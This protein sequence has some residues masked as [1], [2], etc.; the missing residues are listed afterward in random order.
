M[1]VLPVRLTRIAPAGTCTSPRLPTRVNRLFSTMNAESSMGALPSPVIS[2][3]PSN[4]VTRLAPA[5]PVTCD[6]HAAANNRHATTS[7]QEDILFT[8]HIEVSYPMIHLLGIFRE[9]RIVNPGFKDK[10]H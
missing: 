8:R 9:S 2:R 5:W 4:T 7:T 6:E 3:A 10:L 1:T